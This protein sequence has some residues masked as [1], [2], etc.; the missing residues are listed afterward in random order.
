[1]RKFVAVV[2]LGVLAAIDALEDQSNS[3]RLDFIARD[4]MSFLRESL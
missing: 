2:V 3:E 4:C 1:M